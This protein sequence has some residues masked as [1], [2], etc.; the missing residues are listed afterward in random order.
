MIP[1]E[2]Y[3]SRVPSSG[4]LLVVGI[5]STPAFVGMDSFLCVI[6]DCVLTPLVMRHWIRKVLL[7][8]NAIWLLV[9]LMS[10][11][12]KGYSLFL[13]YYLVVLV[14][15]MTR[16]RPQRNTETSKRAGTHLGTLLN[17]AGFTSHRARLFGQ[18]PAPQKCVLRWCRTQMREGE[19]QFF[20]K[21]PGSGLDGKAIVVRTDKVNVEASREGRREHV[22]EILILR[23]QRQGDTVKMRGAVWT[24]TF[25]G[26]DT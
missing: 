14:K 2:C 26:T 18:W 1:K 3:V 19:G 15:D 7:G 25:G 20:N 6:L 17:G 23:F 5:G 9:F 13:M 10:V 4:S 22:N 8:W 24:T 21:A 11:P 16:A 12:W